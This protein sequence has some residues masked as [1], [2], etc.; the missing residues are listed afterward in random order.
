MANFLAPGLQPPEALEAQGLGQEQQML[1]EALRAQMGG[2]SVN[3][4][5]A[6]RMNVL[7]LEGISNALRARQS[8]QEL[9]LSKQKQADL[10]GRYQAGLL[11]AME[12]YNSGAKDP[13]TMRAARSSPYAEVRAL[14]EK[15]EKRYNERYDK[16]GDRASFDTLQRSD[17]NIAALAAKPEDRVVGESIVRSVEGGTPA[18]VA[19]GWKA[20]PPTP[21]GSPTQVNALTGRVD[22]V[23]KA[24]QTNLRVDAGQKGEEAFM[25]AEGKTLSE[26]AQKL[27]ET[28][29]TQISALDRIKDAIG[30]G[31]YQ[32]PM[33]K[34]Q[35]A[36][37]GILNQLGVSSDDQKRVL[38][39]TEAMNSD[40]GRFV[41]AA[42]SALGA[43][44]SNADREYAIQTAG[45][46][47]LSAAGAV[48]VIE[49]AKR[50]IATSVQFHNEHVNRLA[51]EMPRAAIAEVIIPGLERY[52]GMPPV[53]P[54]PGSGSIED[55]VRHYRTPKGK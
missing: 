38:A 15:D 6:G 7:N 46:Q 27:R 21:R 49:A 39:N 50:D 17:G 30:A 3:P 53:Q 55:L 2:T 9:Q 18:L 43:N 4:A 51:R 40:V 1:L 20:G 31:T 48:R 22:A 33:G 16:L 47:P 10:T 12:K 11:Q 41:S 25:A 19:G 26:R 28:V 44:P 54:P 34:Y 8:A 13:A 29:P 36:A 14:A 24:P 35:Q 32:G 37:V 52:S 23:D 45:G 5:A 42:I